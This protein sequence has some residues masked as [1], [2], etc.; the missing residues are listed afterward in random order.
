MSYTRA[1]YAFES[2][3]RNI[4]HEATRNEEDESISEYNFNKAL[5]ALN[6]ADDE[7]KKSMKF[8]EL[9]HQN[10]KTLE[11]AFIALIGNKVKELNEMVSRSW[12]S[13]LFYNIFYPY[14]KGR[15]Q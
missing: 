6:S 2:F 13:Q 3:A 8:A 11:A 15:F 9:T 5:N 10:I 4:Q 14:E 12:Y 7:L 1:P